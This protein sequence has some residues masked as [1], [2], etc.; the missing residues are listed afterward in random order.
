MEN[1][2][3][4]LIIDKLIEQITS[5][6]VSIPIIM[7]TLIDMLDKK[8]FI[9]KAEYEKQLEE[10]FKKTYENAIKNIE[11]LTKEIEKE[12]TAKKIEKGNIILN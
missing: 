10:A 4:E 5:I 11:N 3:I 2:E 1:K 6:Q 8:G 12:E 9:E 7:D